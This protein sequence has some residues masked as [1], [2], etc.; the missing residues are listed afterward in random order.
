MPIVACSLCIHTVP[1]ELTELGMTERDR[2]V[3]MGVNNA[4]LRVLC[5]ELMRS[6]LCPLHIPRDEEITAP[7][8]PAHL[9]IG[10]SMHVCA[11]PLRNTVVCQH[12]VW[13]LCA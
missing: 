13:T 6:S 8:K 2:K 4:A 5:A 1:V 3:H 7:D 11:T 9:N 12:C 10:V